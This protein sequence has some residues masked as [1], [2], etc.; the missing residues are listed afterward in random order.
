MGLESAHAAGMRCVVVEGTMPRERLD[1]A[2]AVVS[3]LNW[4]IPLVEGW[5]E[6]AE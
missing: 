4:S 1:Q 5:N 2:D 3:A 6:H